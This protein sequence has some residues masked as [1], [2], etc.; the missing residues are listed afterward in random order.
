LR[1]TIGDVSTTPAAT[2]QTARLELRPVT[3][4]IAVAILEGRRRSEL[5]KIVGAELPWAWPGRALVEQAFRASL[6]AIVADPETR[7]WGDRLMVTREAAPRVVGSVVFHGRPGPDGECEVAF[8]V[9]EQSQRKGYAHE[10]VSACLDW[11]LAQPECKV[12]VGSAM[13][14][15]KGSLKLLEKL[16]MKPRPTTEEERAKETIAF[17]KRRG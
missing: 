15:D 16:G 5:E 12:V 10:A 4:P 1:G 14:W 6:D 13:R 3:L 8:G 17:E 7:L 2:I 11:A 9:E